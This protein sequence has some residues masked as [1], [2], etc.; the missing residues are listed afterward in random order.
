MKTLTPRDVIANGGVP[1]DDQLEPFVTGDSKEERELSRNTLRQSV[2]S[3]MR[4][5]DS[6]DP[7]TRAATLDDPIVSIDEAKPKRST[8]GT[9]KGTKGGK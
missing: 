2:T 1:T 8:K 3:Y 5:L 4:S 6:V 9:S 7:T